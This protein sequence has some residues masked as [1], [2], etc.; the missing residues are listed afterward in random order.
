LFRRRRQTISPADLWPSRGSQLRLYPVYSLCQRM[1]CTLWW[2]SGLSLTITIVDEHGAASGTMAGI[3]IAPTVANHE[4]HAQVDAAAR[5]GVQ[6]H[7]GQRIA[8]G[9]VVV[10]VV[11]A[12]DEFVHR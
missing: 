12:A 10:V 9:A 11:E 6:Q 5:G 4:A 8:A 3:D 7:A 1:H 2:T